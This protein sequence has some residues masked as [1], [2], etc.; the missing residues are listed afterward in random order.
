VVRH[1]EVLNHAPLSSE[2]ALGACWLG[3]PGVNANQEGEL[4]NAASV[5]SYVL[6]ANTSLNRAGGADA[7]AR[8][9]WLQ[10]SFTVHGFRYAE[11]SGL[12]SAPSAADFEAVVI[13]A[14]VS[15]SGKLKLSS[16][17]LQNIQNAVVWSQRANAQDIF[18]DC[19]QRDERL[20]W[21]GDAAISAEEAL[22]NFGKGGLAQTYVQFLQMIADEQ[23]LGGNI[24]DIVPAPWQLGRMS[25]SD[26]N[27]GTAWPTIAHT[28][29]QTTGDTTVIK[30]H[31]PGLVRYVDSLKHPLK[32][33][34]GNLGDWFP[35]ENVTGASKPLCSASAYI[36]NARQVAAMAGAVNDTATAARM[37]A[38]AAALAIEFNASFLTSD[39]SNYGSGLQ[40]ENAIALWLGLVPAAAQPKVLAS[41]VASIV[42]NKHHVTTG[43]LGTRS[44]YE[45]LAQHG[46]MDLALLLLNQSTAPSYGYMVEHGDVVGSTTLWEKWQ[47][48]T[49]PDDQGDA[50]RNHIM[51]G[52][53]GAFFWH[54]LAGLTPAAPGWA[55]VHVAPKTGERCGKR[56]GGSMSS[57][58]DRVLHAVQG[59][60]DTAA[61]RVSVSWRLGRAAVELALNV[62]LQEENDS[63]SASASGGYGSGGR[64]AF[65]VVPCSNTA[66]TVT[67]NGRLVWQAGRGAAPLLLQE[68][69]V[70]SVR[71]EGQGVVIEV[72]AGLHHFVRQSTQI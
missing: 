6:S 2:V 7:D 56:A 54:H 44:L 49:L 22:L 9:G 8:A 48:D 19:P 12:R 29:W 62:S 33:M 11:V 17:L 69:G 68:A 50:S 71:R 38:L 53:I 55:S 67:L 65:V 64:R 16:P 35:P 39:Q 60:L 37:R 4:V 72:G 36:T 40:T 21:M 61:G 14:N 3:N 52:A 10:P 13:G 46:R 20:G 23:G 25:P 42:E 51:F 45:A 66:A 1:C 5:D 43:I 27:W 70:R 47:A 41:L 18:T 28:V 30:Q 58:D 31:L 59:D 24:P 32:T 63:A 15:Q 57:S 26:P 34:P